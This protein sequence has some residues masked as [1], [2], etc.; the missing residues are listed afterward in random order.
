M[1]F[2][3]ELAERRNT[4]TR[5]IQAQTDAIIEQQEV[6]MSMAAPSIEGSVKVTGEFNI[7]TKKLAD[8]TPILKRNA[9]AFREMST[10]MAEFQVNY[11]ASIE[12]MI[13]EMLVGFGEFL[14]ALAIGQNTAGQFANAMLEPIAEMSIKLGKLIIA[15]AVAIDAIF[16][17]LKFGSPAIAIA[18]GVAL[19]ALGTAIKGQLSSLSSVASGAGGVAAP[20]QA[21][22]YQY[23]TRRATGLQPQTI[24]VEVV[25]EF[26]Q[27]GTDLVAVIN[28]ENKRVTSVT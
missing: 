17:T 1:N 23:D 28:R 6:M 14:G 7:D 5:A 12:A 20:M 3:R 21:P 4:L 26:V 9:E 10:A 19:I 16:K 11:G 25:G 18:A 2:Q 8:L 27:R 13:E 22:D 15:D 24:R